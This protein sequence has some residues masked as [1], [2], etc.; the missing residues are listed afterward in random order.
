MEAMSAEVGAGAASFPM[1]RA[2][3]GTRISDSAPKTPTRCVTR[4]AS[5]CI[6]RYRTKIAGRRRSDS[7]QVRPPELIARLIVMAAH[8]AGSQPAEAERGR[9]ARTWTLRLAWS[10]LAPARSCSFEPPARR[11]I[12]RPEAAFEATPVVEALTVLFVDASIA[13]SANITAG[14]G[15]S[16]T[17]PPPTRQPNP[18]LPDPGVY[19]V[20]LT[21]TTDALRRHRTEADY[22]RVIELP[23]ADFEAAPQAAAPRS[24]SPLLT[25]SALAPARSIAGAGTSAT[26]APQAARGTVPHL[27]R[28]GALHRHLT[29][30]T[31]D[32]QDTVSKPEFVNVAGRPTADFSTDFTPGVAPL[33]VQFTDESGSRYRRN[34]QLDRDF[35]DGAMSSGSEPAPHLHRARRLHR[36][37][38]HR[39]RR[40]KR[41][42]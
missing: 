27:R 38:R 17:E 28:A 9:M 26:E 16:A 13:G 39:N 34:H 6:L 11:A 15:T 25:L 37:P 3:G 5:M 12:R 31:A 18:H 29:V 30:T 41:P 24:P 36:L 19:N 10:M 2:G 33:A 4:S 14:S 20:S 42:H 32:G 7:P 1:P 8:F 35:G 23:V 40:R 21:V 22:I